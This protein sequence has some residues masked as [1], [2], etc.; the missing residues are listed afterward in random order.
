ML[1]F[2]DLSALWP[3][4]QDQ[5]RS[6]ECPSSMYS[7][8]KE[9]SCWAQWNFKDLKLQNQVGTFR[10]SGLSRLLLVIE[11]LHQIVFVASQR[12]GQLPDRVQALVIEVVDLIDSQQMSRLVKRG[13]VVKRATAIC[14]GIWTGVD[15]IGVTFAL[16]RRLHE[17]KNELKWN[18]KLK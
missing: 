3:A 4:R 6:R 1:A 5:W 10:T 9:P 15:F 16:I 12:L 14:Q 13:R 18:G 2:Q 17:L 7:T 8:V 11:A